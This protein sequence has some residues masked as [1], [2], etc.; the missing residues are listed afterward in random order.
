MRRT[1]T[2]GLAHHGLI[3]RRALE[4]QNTRRQT[5]ARGDDRLAVFPRRGHAGNEVAVSHALSRRIS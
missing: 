5:R 2:E 4:Q 3:G 1:E